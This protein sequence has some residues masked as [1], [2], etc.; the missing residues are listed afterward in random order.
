[1]TNDEW[2]D[3]TRP[4]DNVDPQPGPD[5]GCPEDYED[6]PDYE[7]GEPDM[8]VLYGLAPDERDKLLEDVRKLRE[9]KPDVSFRGI[10]IEKGEERIGYGS[11]NNNGVIYFY[12]GFFDAPE[13]D[14]P[15]ILYHE[16]WHRTKEHYK[17]SLTQYPVSGIKNDPPEE[18]KQ[19]ILEDIKKSC[20]Y[21]NDEE[22]KIYYYYEY[23]KV[24]EIR[25]AE[26]YKNEIEAYEVEK[27]LF[28]DDM[29]SE[30][31]RINRD[32]AMWNYRER[33]KILNNNN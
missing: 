5:P 9:L 31:Y 32:I 16:Y 7:P 29:I 26:F 1:M 8:P 23:I 11:I 25:N 17:V 30:S 10:R 27:S 33:L 2:M 15:A 20:P 22:I 6:I 12:K 19:R 18:L 4:D 13:K 3:N 24:D 28:I 14:R 21:A